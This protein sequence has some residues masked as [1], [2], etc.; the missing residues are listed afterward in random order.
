LGLTYL[1]HCK[2][3]SKLL[4]YLVNSILDLSQIR[5][6]GLKVVKD[7][8]N[9]DQCL[10]EVKSLYIYASQSKKIQFIVQKM[11]R[12][13]SIIDTDQHRLLEILINLLGNAIKFTFTGHVKLKVSV[14]EGKESKLLFEVEDTGIGIAEKDK[15]K[16]FQMFGKLNQ[17][18]KN[19]N[20][21]GVG[22]GLTIANEL[23]KAL[24]E[25]NS[26]GNE[27]K[28]HFESIPNKG[29]RFWFRIDA[30]SEDLV[31][32]STADQ[33]S[34]IIPPINVT[35]IGLE[36]DYIGVLK[37]GILDHRPRHA[38]SSTCV[39]RN[40]SP[41]TSPRKM[42]SF[43]KGD[44]RVLIVDDNPFNLL[45]AKFLMEKLGFLISTASHGEE[46]L[47]ML[48]KTLENKEYFDIILMDIQMPLMDGL[49]ASRLI[50]SKIQNGEMYKV[51]IIGLTAQKIVQG[52][53]RITHTACGMMEV[54]E[55]PL[56]ED[57]MRNILDGLKLSVNRWGTDEK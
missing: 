31:S 46:C 33:E 26:D 20:T 45:A 17:S 48:E 12:V 2:S 47:S 11:P 16:L 23:V 35:K 42:R 6:N 41:Q 27:H 54:L 30:I 1:D 22:L 32:K 57:T 38:A 13:P 3:C 8:F 15:P 50:T 14:D 53:D 51:P 56:V 18:N 24:N 28:I 43:P 5:H 39:S 29:S 19:I 9:L 10:E 21:H 49:E 55:K 44:K 36:D 40:T 52:R 25:D 34:F 7:K 4:L 37:R